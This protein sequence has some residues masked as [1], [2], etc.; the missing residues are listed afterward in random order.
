MGR[1]R[2]SC[3]YVP[4]EGEKKE[5]ISCPNNAILRQIRNAAMSSNPSSNIDFV[6]LTSFAG[7]GVREDNSLKGNLMKFKLL[8]NSN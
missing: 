2:K 3:F 1:L 4:Q 5:K 6:P 7:P 8:P